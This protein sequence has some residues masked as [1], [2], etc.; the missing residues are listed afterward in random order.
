MAATD[1]T[2][3]GVVGG[4][5]SGTLTLAGGLLGGVGWRPAIG[6]V[7]IVAFLPAGCDC[8]MNAW[9]KNSSNSMRSLALRRNR[10]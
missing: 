1:T 9:L 7:A 8:R 6:G 5:G 3:R 2:G 4:V 10:P